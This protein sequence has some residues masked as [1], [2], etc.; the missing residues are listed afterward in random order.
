MTNKSFELKKALVEELEGLMEVS[1]SI[2]RTLTQ[3]QQKMSEAEVALNDATKIKGYLNI[4][5]DRKREV[6]REIIKHE[7]GK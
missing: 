7:Q 4:E 6:L 3:A 1:K 5:I 2:Q